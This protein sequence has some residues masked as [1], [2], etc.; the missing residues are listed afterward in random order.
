MRNGYR[1]RLKES[2]RKQRSSRFGKLGVVTKKE[3]IDLEDVCLVERGMDEDGR[4]SQR[5]AK[6]GQADDE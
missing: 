2:L 6:E 5:S 3:T 1:R 4:H